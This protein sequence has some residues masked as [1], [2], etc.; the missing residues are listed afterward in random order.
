MKGVFNPN[1]PIFAPNSAEGFH[2]SAFHAFGDHRYSDKVSVVYP[3]Q[4]VLFC[5]F[6]HSFGY[7]HMEIIYILF[8]FAIE[9]V[10]NTCLCLI[11]TVNFDNFFCRNQKE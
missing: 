8:G 10:Q 2:F 11:K 6:K 4:T 3:G 7:L 1:I 9:H 5:S